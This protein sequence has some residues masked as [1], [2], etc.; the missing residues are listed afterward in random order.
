ML[1]N[2]KIR[3]NIP[4]V[5]NY[6]PKDEA[7]K[8]G[9]MALFGEKYG[10]VVRVVIIDPAYSIELCGGTHIGHTGEIGYFK[11]MSETSIAAGVRRME[12]VCGKQAEAYVY[13]QFNLMRSIRET[14]KNPKDVLKTIE[15]LSTENSEL[16]KKIEKLEAAQIDSLKNDLLQKAVQLNG[17][18]FIG[19]VIEAS[20][21]EAL[22]KLCFDLRNQLKSYVIVLA[23]NIEGK[24]QVAVAIDE[25]ISSS[26]NLDASKM[27][28]EQIAPL[29][30][31]GGGGQKTL[32][33]AG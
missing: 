24:A 32:A 19:E 26:K 27:I 10:D 9:A 11:I 25:E 18:T 12:A 4:V 7:L 3:K 5:I 8:L 17:T 6:M 28:R 16:R 20:S 13:E 14:L 29:I 1:V 2:E 33:T 21:G 23:S 22:K 30:K 15:N 31:G